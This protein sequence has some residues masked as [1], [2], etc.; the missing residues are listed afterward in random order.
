MT[1][2]IHPRSQVIIDSLKNENPL[3]DTKTIISETIK[4]AQFVAIE[5]AIRE[6]YNTKEMKNE[7]IA[8]YKNRIIR[9]ISRAKGRDL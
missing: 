3:F 2:A 4:T 8:K 1:G 6:V 5:A 7:T 9:N